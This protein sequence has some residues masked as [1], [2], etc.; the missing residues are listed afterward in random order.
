MR[1][2]GRAAGPVLVAVPLAVAFLGPFAAGWLTP[3]DGAPY[4]LGDGHPLGTDGMGRDVLALLLR[5]G[6][7][8]LGAA[9]GAVATACLVG[10]PL[11]LAAAV[12][13]H[14]WLDEL[15]LRPVELLLPI[16]SLLVISVT[17]VWWRGQP[18]AIA[19]TVALINVP[20]VARLVRAAALDAAS[21]PVVEAMRQQGESRFRILGG[22]V[23]RVVAP[24]AAADAGTR[25]ATAVFTVAAANFLGLGLEPTAP[26][27]AVTVAAGR[28]AL[29]VQPLAVCAPAAMLVMFTVG[30]NLTADRL[31][32]RNG[33]RK[34]GRPGMPGT[35][36]SV[37]ADDDRPE[38]GV[39]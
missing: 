12:T 1:G 5:G 31:V 28:E 22:Y 13:R 29:L 7:S 14:R 9:L 38:G 27:W 2:A 15:L 3:P 19:L 32:R 17:A 37:R 26:D 34:P 10:G 20:A 39:R 36:R 23:G 25:V 21:G 35:P 18:L 24:V 6:R 30:L 8:A 33:P 11:G 4:A 16:P